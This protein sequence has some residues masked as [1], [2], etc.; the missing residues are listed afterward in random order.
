MQIIKLSAI[1]STNSYLKS[2]M[3]ERKLTDF[4][5]VVAENQIQ[6]RGQMGTTWVSEEG[7]NL[8]FSTLKKI[9]NFNIEDQF[10]LNICVSLA[11][12]DT[13]NSMQIPDLKVK[14]PNDILSGN[15][16][17]CGVLI[18]NILSGKKI[19]SSIIGIGLNVNQLSF[20]NLPYVS[21]LKLLTGKQFD[22]D[23]V[24][25]N[26]VKNLKK[27][28]L[29]LS[30]NKV[31]ELKE[32]YLKTLFRKDKPST[33][34]SENEQMFTGIIRGISKEGKL[35]VEIE[36]EIIIEFGLKEVKLLY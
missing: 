15:N 16:K 29:K 20:N 13:L 5:V 3:L 34:K 31:E 10:L 2:M 18:E 24:L 8:T 33:F 14:W 23:E 6:G 17:I 1:D 25:L 11:V 35:L 7:K 28:F 22:L 12:Y 36:D 32:L 26:L 27:S 30:E 9:T 21:S 19:Q 4:T